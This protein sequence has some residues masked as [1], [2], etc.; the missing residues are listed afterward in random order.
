M[1]VFRMR[2]VDVGVGP[3]AIDGVCARLNVLLVHTV[4]RRQ[5]RVARRVLAVKCFCSSLRLRD[6]SRT[7]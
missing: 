6:S 2:V 7:L 3:E 1:F 4:W 5:G